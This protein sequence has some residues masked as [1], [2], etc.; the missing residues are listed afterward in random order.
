MEMFIFDKIID[1]AGTFSAKWQNQSSI[2]PD[3]ISM[4]VAD[5]DLPA[6]EALIEQLATFNHMGIYG[7]TQLPENYFD[8]VR[9]YLERHYSYKVKNDEIVFCPRI[10]QAIS[11]YLREFT[12]IGE[13]IC[14]FT[15]SY[16]PIINAITL[17]NRQFLPCPLV[18]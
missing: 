6:P 14:V 5:M 18:Y 1:R 8:V 15:P 13:K 9:N 11:I 17:N 4:S 2:H 16:S 10:I 3:F 7:Y 12:Q